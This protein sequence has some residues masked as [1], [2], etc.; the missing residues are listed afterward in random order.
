MYNFNYLKKI[1]FFFF[2]KNKI[3][4]LLFIFLFFLYLYYDYNKNMKFEKAS[5]LYNNINYSLYHSD[6]HSVIK[7]SNFLI[8]KYSDTYYKDSCLLILSS[9]E[10][11]K[12]NLNNSSFYL[13]KIIEKTNTGLN[14]IALF[15]LC[16]I[17]YSNNM[18][19]ESFD[20]LN[21]I[22]EKTY[23]IFYEEMKGDIFSYINENEKAKIAYLH[24]LNFIKNDYNIF[25][26]K[27]KI[28]NLGFIV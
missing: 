6:F 4:Y 1:F 25:S 7:L 2:I 20:L 21:I 19:K 27:I 28:N 12:N 5:N 8:E 11:K 16:K 3:F 17:Y 14:N 24:S 23:F 9:I 10:F 18:I 13:K 26:I 15:R 22:K